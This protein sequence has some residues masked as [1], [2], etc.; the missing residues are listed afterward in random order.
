RTRT[1]DENEQRDSFAAAIK[2]IE[3]ASPRGLPRA[4]IWQEPAEPP[5]PTQV[6]RR[7]NPSTPAGT[8]E[9]G[10]PAVLADAA[11]PLIAR[12]AADPTT[13]RRL[14]LARWLT[15]PRNPLVARVIVNRL[16]QGHF[17]EGIVSTENDFGVMGSSPTHAEL[18]DWLATEM[19][20]S[21]SAP[22]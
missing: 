12:G 17:G 21:S 16:W 1:A 22:P 9:P 7:G 13:L 3:A 4:Y 15:G 2:T 6:F 19:M 20:S 8:V 10:F 18:L 11:M 14:S 5:P